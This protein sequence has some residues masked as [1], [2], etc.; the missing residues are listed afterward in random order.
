MLI[1]A[2]ANV[3]ISSVIA[4][5]FTLDLLFSDKL[6][7]VVPDWIFSEID[8]HKEEILE[9]SGISQDEFELFLGIIKACIEIVESSE[10]KDFMERA[11]KISVDP[12]DVQYFALALKLSC[13]IWSN[14]PHFKKQSEV[15]V[16]TTKELDE[17]LK[18]QE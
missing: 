10:L 18:R 6:E 7:V 1:V 11:D 9:I 15:E 3:L 8:E 2:D 16:L 13:P 12:D 17:F 14:D 5:G 4:K